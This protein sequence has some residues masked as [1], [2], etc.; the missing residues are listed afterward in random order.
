[1]KKILLICGLLAANVLLFAQ[2]SNQSTINSVN[3]HDYLAG[4]VGTEACEIDAG[5]S[6]RGGITFKCSVNCKDGYYACCGLGCECLSDEF[7][8]PTDPYAPAIQ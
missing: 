2:G 4:G 8:K 5:I 7:A 1:M 6:F 3:S